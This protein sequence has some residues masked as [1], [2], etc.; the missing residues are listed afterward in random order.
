MTLLLVVEYMNCKKGSDRI[1]GGW[2]TEGKRFVVKMLGEIKQDERRGIRKKWEDTS[3]KKMS[4]ATKQSKA[5]AVEEDDESEEQF[6][7]DA[8]MLYAEV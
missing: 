5:K 4:K 3:R 6:E 2:S 8:N 1:A 7:M